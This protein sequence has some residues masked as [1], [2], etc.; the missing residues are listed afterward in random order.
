ME[1]SHRGEINQAP[2]KSDVTRAKVKGN[3]FSAFV[4][5]AVLMIYFWSWGT[6]LTLVLAGAFGTA[7]LNQSSFPVADMYISCYLYGM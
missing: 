3:S 2:D 4:L 1:L 7:R 5:I 6:D